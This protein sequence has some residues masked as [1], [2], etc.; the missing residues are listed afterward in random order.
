LF[1][2][3]LTGSLLAAHP[4]IAATEGRLVRPLSRTSTWSTPSPDPTGLTYIPTTGRFLISDSEVEEGAL[5]RRKNLFFATRTGALVATRRVQRVNPEPEAIVWY[6]RTRSL[7]VADDDHDAIYRFVPGRDGQIGTLDDVGSKLLNT[8]R[9]GSYDPEGLAWIPEFRVFVWVD[10]TDRRVYKVRSGPDHRFGTRDDGVTRFGTFR[11][12]FT[13]PEGVTWD[14]ANRHFFM[15]SS[16]QKYVLETTGSGALVRTIDM[17]SFCAAGCNLSD[18]VFAPGTDGSRRRL[19]LTDRGVDNNTNPD[20]GVYNDG[21]L[22]QVKF[23]T[24]P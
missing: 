15:V 18:L 14:G 16:S 24:V 19:Y 20:P 21:K 7:F 11:Y 13:D 2:C 3:A 6:A 5:W 17:S 10:A 12:G 1:L 22:Y 8:R 4:A 23:V 9:F